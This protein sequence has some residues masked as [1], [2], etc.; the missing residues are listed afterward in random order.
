MHTSRGWL[1]MKLIE[2]DMKVFY[3]A[4]YSDR[5]MIYDTNGFPT[6]EYTRGY[7][8]Q[9]EAAGT[10]SSASG[11]A[12]EKE[13]GTFID[14]DYIIH[15]EDETCPFDENAAIWL[16]GTDPKDDHDAKAIRISESASHTAVAVKKIR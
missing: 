2:R 12:S 1:L 14:Y 8:T 6:G 7:G 13:F 3:Y 4:A 11:R 10:F 16:P 5:T 9:V 15:L